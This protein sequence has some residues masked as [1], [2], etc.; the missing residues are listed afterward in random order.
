MELFHAIVLGIVQGLTE[1][2]PISSSGHLILVPALFRWKDQGLA[3]DAGLHLGTLAALLVYFW[4]DWWEMGLAG[5]RDLFSGALLRGKPSSQ[6]RLLLLLALGTIPAA[7]AGL[8][9]DSWIEANVREPWIVAIA[10]AVVATLM[11]AADRRGRMTRTIGDIGLLDTVLVGLAQACALMNQSHF[12]IDNA[13]KI[14]DFLASG[15]M[16]HSEQINR[17]RALALGVNIADEDCPGE[18]YEIV[19]A[20]LDLLGT[21]P[22]PGIYPD[23]KAEAAPGKPSPLRK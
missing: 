20:H 11:L 10:L 14:T 4:R 15:D 8:L 22:M 5:F 19:E 1:F 23:L 17:T 12:A 6:S 3:F 7:V 9:L 18:I 16:P 2:L 21:M 13:C